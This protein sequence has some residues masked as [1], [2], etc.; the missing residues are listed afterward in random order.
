MPIIASIPMPAETSGNGP[1]ATTFEVSTSVDSEVKV[2]VAARGCM[3]S[4]VV[5]E[6]RSL[7]IVVTGSMEEADKGRD[8]VGETR[9]GSTNAVAAE[10]LESMSNI[11]ELDELDET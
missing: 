11:S 8:A 10:E 5:S 3:A 4:I 9:I 2:M 6:V 1:S 7:D